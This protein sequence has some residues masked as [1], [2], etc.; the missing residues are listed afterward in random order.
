MKRLIL[1][2][3]NDF[4]E[5]KLTAAET[6]KSNANFSS[7]LQTWAFFSNSVVQLRA[8]AKKKDLQ[9]ENTVKV[10]LAMRLE[11]GRNICRDVNVF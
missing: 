4:L 2:E 6:D 7:D 9:I 11:H 10:N 8:T 5:R 1:A 3:K